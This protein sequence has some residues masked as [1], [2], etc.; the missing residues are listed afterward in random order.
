MLNLP[1]PSAKFPVPE[2]AS[3]KDNI[4]A[5]KREDLFSNL[6]NKKVDW[7]S[8]FSVHSSPL[9][10]IDYLLLPMIVRSS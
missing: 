6:L 4:Q 3:N 1:A 7:L 8:V 2:L 9:P 10:V 5:E